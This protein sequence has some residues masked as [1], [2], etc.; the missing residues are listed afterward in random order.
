MKSALLASA[1]ALITACSMNAP[2]YS[3]S[4]DNS[5]VLQAVHGSKVAV[6]TFSAK[7]KEVDNLSLRG[8]SLVSPYEQSYSKYLTKAL[9]E[10][11][12]LAG[13][14][15]NNAKT[16]VSGELMNNQ[17]DISSFSI[18]TASITAKFI[19]T[20]NNN[21]IYEK[22]ISAKHEWESS[23]AGAVAIPAGQTNYPIVIQKLFGN[24][25]ADKDFIK[26]IQKPN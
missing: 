7:N 18:G 23:F 21:K 12:K 11:L 20:N 14:W 9:E 13:I 2:M 3:P 10:E 4:P 22:D 16:R 6:D 8:G 25:F 19:V 24:L 15:D 17:L 5:N 26:A 1:C